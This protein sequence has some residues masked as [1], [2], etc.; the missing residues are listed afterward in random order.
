M[1][2]LRRKQSSAPADPA[3]WRP[4]QFG[5]TGKV[6]DAIVEPAWRG[7]RVLAT[8]EDGRARFVD[9]TG[10]DCTVEFASVAQALIA[11]A[12]ADSMILDGHLTVE[13]TQEGAGI[14]DA[15]PESPGGARVIAQM[16]VGGRVAAPAVTPRRLDPDRP[17]AFVAVDLLAIDGASLLDIPLLER[18]RL[19]DGAVCEDVIIRKTPFIRPPIATFLNT[20]RSLGFEDL[21]W[22]G[23]NSR[24][25]PGERNDEWTISPIPMH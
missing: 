20:W 22:K 24:Y 17:V 16:L 7:V 10:A 23:I 9:E 15:T 13:P 6:G 4:Q 25:R 18:K 3:D 21:V 8:V 12:R 2:L 5:R 1:P 19:L 14:A 11:A